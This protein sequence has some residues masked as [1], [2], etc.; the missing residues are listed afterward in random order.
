MAIEVED[1]NGKSNAESYID[2]AYLSA[3]A[4]KRGLDITGI[5]EAN[6]IK[7]MDYFE[8]AYQ[9]KGTKLKETQALAFP[10]YINNEVVYPVRIKNA[11]C[12]LTIKSKSA[13]LLADSERLTKSEAVGDIKIEYSE[14]S[15]DTV[16]YNFVINLILPW[17]SGSGISA[18]IIRTY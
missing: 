4:A 13:E 2:L 3:Y 15:K 5:S 14:Y 7:A 18:S 10:R 17:L 1:G 11:V 12:E 6:I 9:F 8:S 16:N